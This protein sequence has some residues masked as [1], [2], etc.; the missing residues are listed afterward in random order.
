MGKKGT[1][2]KNCCQILFK[3]TPKNYKNYNP[4]D[5]QNKIQ[6]EIIVKTVSTKL[7]SKNLLRK[8]MAVCQK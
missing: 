8:I 2:F 5:T 3:F 1:Q 4:T 6:N 7:V